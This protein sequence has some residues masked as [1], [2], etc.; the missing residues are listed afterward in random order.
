MA[1]RGTAKAEASHGALRDVMFEMMIDA[2]TGV[3][4]QYLYWDADN[5][6]TN[7]LVV[8]SL[9]YDSPGSFS[10]AEESVKALIA[11]NKNAE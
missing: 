8:K 7:V 4:L 11:Q 6:F 5:N 2:E 3:I 1:I 10:D 9:S